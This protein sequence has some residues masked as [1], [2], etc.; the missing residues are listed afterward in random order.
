MYAQSGTLY[1][2]GIN[3]RTLDVNYLLEVHV[4]KIG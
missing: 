1:S 2:L 4:E 3:V